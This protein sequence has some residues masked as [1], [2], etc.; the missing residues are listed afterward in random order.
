VSSDRPP[1]GWARCNLGGQPLSPGDERVIADFT[2]TLAA[3]RSDPS[4]Q[5]REL[6]TGENGSYWREWH[7]AVPPPGQVYR[8]LDSGWVT[9][10]EPPV[11]RIYRIELAGPAAGPQDR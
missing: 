8:V 11:R 9:E 10:D 4:V 6:V 3:R 1:G 2:A 7:C 5:W